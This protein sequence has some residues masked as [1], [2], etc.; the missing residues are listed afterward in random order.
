[1]T[2]QEE[3]KTVL[4]T[5][6]EWSQDRPLWQRD[7]LRRIVVK[8]E[9]DKTDISELTALCKKGQGDT[10]QLLDAVPLAQEHLPANPGSSPPVSLISVTDV[11]GVNN[12]SP[13][14]EL[15]FEKSGLS[16]IYGDNGAGKSGYARILKRACRARFPGKIEPNIFVTPGQ[17]SSPQATISFLIGGGAPVVES[18]TNQD[19]PHSVLSAISVFD[20]DSANVHI[21]DK[22]E[23]AYRPFGLDIP[24]ELARVSQ[25]VK[26][27]LNAE[28][29]ALGKA[30]N[31]LFAKPTWKETTKAGKLLNAL[32]YNSD[33]AEMRSLGELSVLDIE[34]L[35][36]LR[37]DLS[38]DIEKAAG[39]QALK[40]DN[41]KRLRMAVEQ[42]S[43]GSTDEELFFV[44]SLHKAAR[45]KR[46]AASVA[47]DVAFSGEPIKEVGGDVWRALWSAARNFATEVAFPSAPFP[48]AD[49]GELCVLCQQ[50]LSSQALDRMRRFEQF[51]QEDTER[52]GSLAFYSTIIYNRNN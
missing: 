21:N 52:Q 4:E 16:V 32:D 48:P 1:M 35:S 44:F 13:N 42:M 47:A 14:Q 19:Y 8:G 33:V 12:L 50:L 29:D 51:I 26:A 24:D 46:H 40:A 27:A 23:V 5:I 11:R 7:A 25:E 20:S 2:N 15:A 37:E 45:E 28:K 3:P 49:A 38:K 30:R 39:E 43:E 6:L 9:L 36:R 22:N 18:W 17:A 31:P 10:A 41:L 34:R